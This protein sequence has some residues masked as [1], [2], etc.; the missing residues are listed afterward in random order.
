MDLKSYKSIST[1]KHELTKIRK[2]STI[3][4]TKIETEL[5]RIEKVIYRLSTKKIILSN[6]FS[7]GPLEIQNILCFIQ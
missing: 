6:L 7:R 2:S 1:R 4:Y 3:K 5:L